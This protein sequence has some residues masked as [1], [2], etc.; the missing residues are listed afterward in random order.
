MLHLR[1]LL[2]KGA[3]RQVLKRSILRPVFLLTTGLGFLMLETFFFHHIFQFLF[4]SLDTSL[5][6]LSNALSLY[7]LQLLFLVFGMML[8]YS[9]VVTSI[10]VYLTADDM[11]LLLVLPVRTWSLYLS[12]FLETVT[13]SSIALAAFM[14]PALITYGVAREAAPGFYAW[15]PILVLF[16]LVVP[17]GVAVPAML[18]LAR[19]FPARRLQQGLFVVGLLAATAGLF[20]FRMLRVEDFFATGTDLQAM[21]KWAASFQLPTRSW[22]PSN[23][24]VRAIDRLVTKPTPGIWGAWLLGASL[25]VGGGSCLLGTP[26]LRGT[27]SRAFSIPRRNLTAGRW[28]R[29]GSFKL[30]GLSRTDSAMV[31]KELKVFSRDLTRWSQILI[32]IPLVGFYLL[33]MYMLP[34]RDQFQGLYY[35]LNLFMIAFIVAAIGARYL[36]PSVSWEGPALWIVRVSP[37]PVWRLVTIK[38]I[39]FSLPLLLL[40]FLLTVFS[41]RILDLSAGLLIASLRMALATTLFLA[42]LAIG[43]GALLP[44]F[45]YEHHLEISLGPGGLLYMFTALGVSFLFVLVLAYPIFEAM[46]QGAASWQT[47]SF[48]ELVLPSPRTECAWIFACLLGAALSLWMG[49]VSLSRREEFDR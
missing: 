1:L 35:L 19:I 36:F 3:I 47:W 23:W 2:W 27:W 37:Y 39:T 9:N 44:K 48:S 10:S 4:H 30:P 33:N 40:T 49:V 15:V 16:F 26:L 14:M 18:A 13:R 7:I 38:F 34:M 8:V 43:F 42:A 22:L 25:V 5:F 28:F 29:F 21:A 45:R 32:V 41:F 12:K 31:L 20:A 6:A 24:L 11:K 46:G 17:A